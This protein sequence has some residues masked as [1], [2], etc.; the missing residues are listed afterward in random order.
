MSLRPRSGPTNCTLAPGALALSWSVLCSLYSFRAVAWDTQPLRDTSSDILNEANKI[1]T[2]MKI[3]KWGGGHRDGT[4]PRYHAHARIAHNPSPD[5]ALVVKFARGGAGEDIVEAFSVRVR[6]FRSDLLQRLAR[7]EAGLCGTRPA[8]GVVDAIGGGTVLLEIV[9]CAGEWAAARLFERLRDG[10]EA[11]VWVENAPDVADG[12]VGGQDPVLGAEGRHVEVAGRNDQMA[13]LDGAAQQF[14]KLPALRLAV[15]AVA[16]LAVGGVR[17]VGVRVE[18]SQEVVRAR[19]EADVRLGNA[20]ANI[21]I[22]TPECGGTP[23]EGVG[24]HGGFFY[25]PVG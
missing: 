16:V 11:A 21:P 4:Y 14:R 6:R 10:A 7:T 23:V 20:F 9:L 22:A 12:R 25:G 2:K 18:D 15:Y 13:P 19:A 5:S 8:P 24:A 1:K 3:K 17:R